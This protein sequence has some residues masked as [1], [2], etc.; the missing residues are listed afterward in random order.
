[1]RNWYRIGLGLFGLV[2]VVLLLG[3]FAFYKALRHVPAFYEDALKADPA[4]QKRASDKMVKETLALISDV[5][6]EGRWQAVF[7]EDEINGWLAVDLV[8][9]HADMLPGTVSDPRVFIRPEGMTVGFRY[10]EN[11]RQTVITLNV[12]AYLVEPNVVGLRIRTIRAGLLPLPL[13][14]V[15]KQIARATDQ[16]EWR[17]EWRQTDGDPVA[18][19]TIPPVRDQRNKIIQVETLHLG[20]KQVI[21]AGTTRRK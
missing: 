17:V 9:N 21:L 6:R 12:D 1:V 18:Q 11:D 20:D 3:G 15:L 16:L 8:R 13:D 10:R 5:R 4:Q 7:T 19:I 2:I 14:D